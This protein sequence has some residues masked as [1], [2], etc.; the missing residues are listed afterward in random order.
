LIILYSSPPTIHINR[1]LHLSFTHHPPFI[2]S[3]PTYIHHL[4]PVHLPHLSYQQY[5]SI[6]ENH[7]SFLKQ[8]RPVTPHTSSSSITFIIYLL[9]LFSIIHV[10]Y[11]LPPSSTF[12]HPLLLHHSIPPSPASSIICF[13]HL[14]LP[15]PYLRHLLPL[16]TSYSITFYLL[17]R[18]LLRPYLHHLL[19]LSSSYSITFYLYHHHI[20]SL[21]NYIIHRPHHLLPHHFRPG[22]LP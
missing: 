14:S 2:L 10:L 3:S 17:H 5:S 18:F 15:R 16:S 8:S 13:L 6:L 21:F 19:P 12:C 7:R 22:S 1:Y 9:P 4:L 11:Q 20:P